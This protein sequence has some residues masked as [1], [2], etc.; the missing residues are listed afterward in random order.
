M[1]L[2]T[3]AGLFLYRLFLQPPRIPPD[4]PIVLNLVALAEPKPAQAPKPAPKQVEPAQPPAQP[5]KPEAVVK[6]PASDLK[7]LLAKKLR[8]HREKRDQN[9]VVP[10]PTPMRL[11]DRVPTVRPVEVPAPKTSPKPKSQADATGPVSVELPGGYRYDY[12]LSAIR[13]TL[14]R[15]WTVPQI[16]NLQRCMTT[17]EITLVRDGRVL[18]HRIQRKSVSPFFDQ[19]VQDAIR[20]SKFPPFPE[21]HEGEAMTVTVRFRPDLQ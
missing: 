4:A 17:V 1:L 2:H 8:E 6:N 5:P 9:R 13:N 18:S 14:W 11:V 21:D 7:K 19:S 3:G 20:A 10:T 12:Y 16:P 15:N